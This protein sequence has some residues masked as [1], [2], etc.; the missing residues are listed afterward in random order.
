[1]PAIWTE[2]YGRY[3]SLEVEMAEYDRAAMIY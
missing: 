1:M 2:L 3:L